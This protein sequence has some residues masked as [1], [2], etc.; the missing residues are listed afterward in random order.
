MRLHRNAVRLPAVSSFALVCARSLLCLAIACIACGGSCTVWY[1]SDNSDDV[2]PCFDNDPDND[3]NCPDSKP[4]TQGEPP[5]DAYVLGLDEWVL[6]AATEPGRHPVGRLH[7]DQ[8]LALPELWGPGP[9]G[10]EALI[11]FTREVIRA[12][13]ELLAL[14]PAV[15]RL[16]AAGVHALDH[17]LVVEFEQAAPRA[18]LVGGGDLEA[19][20]DAAAW[21]VFDGLLRLV[22]IRNNTLVPAWVALPPPMPQPTRDARDPVSDA[23]RGVGSVP[24]HRR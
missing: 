16:R 18:G 10:D 20:P 21:F 11:A 19:L 7:S 15:G 6:E 23:R 17:V 9:W 1:S 24:T 13:P 4:A 2:H 14:P 3:V 8:G 5:L 22:E 12:N